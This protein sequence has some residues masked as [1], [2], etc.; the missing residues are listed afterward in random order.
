MLQP[1]SAKKQFYTAILGKYQPTS[2]VDFSD[3]SSLLKAILG[4]LAYA[5][6]NIEADWSVQELLEECVLALRMFPALLV[7]DDVDS[8]EPMQQQEVFQSVIQIVNQTA[9]HAGTV[10]SRAILTTRL[11]LGA[12]PAQLMRVAGLDL[13][14]FAEY[15]AMTAESLGVPLKPGSPA[16]KHFRTVTDGSPIFAA[17]ILRLV[18]NGEHLEAALKK[19]KGSDG[20][21]VRKF[22]FKRELDKLSESQIII[23]LS[24]LHVY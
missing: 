8:L 24:M 12:A 7:I 10:P 4:E 20:E 15:V 19:W 21:E 14:D 2:R 16:M 22:A 18:Q 3:L 23:G 6:N 9:G 11:D 17:S 13:T 1:L 5:E